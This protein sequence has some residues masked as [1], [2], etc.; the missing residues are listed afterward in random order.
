MFLTILVYSLIW[1]LLSV[2]QI[3]CVVPEVAYEWLTYRQR[4]LSDKQLTCVCHAI[5][6]HAQTHSC[7]ASETP[8]KKIKLECTK[9]SSDNNYEKKDSSACFNKD[10][11][12]NVSQCCPDITKNKKADTSPNELSDCTDI[13]LQDFG[14]NMRQNGEGDPP[15]HRPCLPLH[16]FLGTGYTPPEMLARYRVPDKD[17]KRYVIM[18]VVNPCSVKSNCFTKRFVRS[19]SYW[20]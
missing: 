11:L 18:D 9:T 4:A 1:S 8:C 10:S 16:F 2:F 7:P 12:T 17:L 14:L 6:H 5:P 3:H 15:S 19:I 13:C 20:I